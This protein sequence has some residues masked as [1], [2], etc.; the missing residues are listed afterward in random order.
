MRAFAYTQNNLNTNDVKSGA[1]FDFFNAV[2]TGDT[3]KLKNMTDAGFDINTKNEKGYTALHLAVMSNDQKMLDAILQTAKAD[4]KAKL[5]SD[6]ILTAKNGSTLKAFGAT[7]LHIA[8]FEGYVQSIKKLLKEKVRADERDDINFATPIHYGAYNGQAETVKCLLQH[9]LQN[10]KQSNL[11]N[12]LD[13]YNRTPLMY[14]AMNYG[15]A[16]M[17]P[18]L[19]HGADLN[20]Y[21]YDGWRALHYTSLLNDYDGTK[22]LLEGGAETNTY[23]KYGYS[24]YDYAADPR[25]K[26]LYSQY[27]RN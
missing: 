24:P 25:V 21:D 10:E 26:N 9:E 15:N 3:N 18:L 6:A 12:A 16:A 17:T 11:V 5:P 13:K 23:N 4:V 14:S 19:Q 20:L 8:A 22:A 27:E 2:E 7:A 1:D